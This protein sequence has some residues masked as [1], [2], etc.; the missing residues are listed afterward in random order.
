MIGGL[1]P[2]L[3]LKKQLRNVL[4]EKR[5]FPPKLK[6]Q[7]QVTGNNQKQNSNLQLP[8]FK[9][10]QFMICISHLPFQERPT[11][12]A[13]LAATKH[14]ETVVS[15]PQTGWENDIVEPIT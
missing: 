7:S 8:K 9:R 3:I 2:T 4:Q 14:V 10:F 6:N 5:T 11:S 13:Q 1:K 12:W 15:S